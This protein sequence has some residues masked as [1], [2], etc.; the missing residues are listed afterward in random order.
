M[1]LTDYDS[2][3]NYTF[4][5][6]EVKDIENNAFSNLQNYG[7]FMHVYVDGIRENIS[8]VTE[9]NAYMDDKQLVYTFFVPVNAPGLY[10]W[11]TVDLAIY[12]ETFF[13][14]IG[15]IENKPVSSRG[16]YAF[17]ITSQLKKDSDTIITYDNTNIS[18]DRRGKNYTGYANPTVAT[19]QF[20]KK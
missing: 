5:P 6:T 3:K 4:S 17:E 10:D 19:I 2:D 7:Y 9:F 14:D 8:S 12:D 16:Y 18:V 1:I 13:C 15:F 20:R 11:R